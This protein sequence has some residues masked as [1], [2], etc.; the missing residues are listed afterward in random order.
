MP[1]VGSQPLGMWEKLNRCVGIKSRHLMNKKPASSGLAGK[2]SHGCAL[3]GVRRNALR[4]GF[5]LRARFHFRDGRDQVT[6]GAWQGP[7]LVEFH[8]RAQGLLELFRLFFRGD[9]ERPWARSLLL[10]GAH[11][12]A[13]NKLRRT[14]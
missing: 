7:N 10:E 1:R 14:S 8:K 4:L 13:S 5:W 12:A 11:R 6:A 2:M 9:N 3:A